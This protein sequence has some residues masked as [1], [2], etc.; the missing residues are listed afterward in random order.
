MMTKVD[1]FSS[2]VPTMEQGLRLLLQNGALSLS[3]DRKRYVAGAVAGEFQGRTLVRLSVCAR[4]CGR[5]LDG[6]ADGRT[7]EMYFENRPEMFRIWA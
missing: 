2:Y 1:I 3:A 6:E 7:F 4:H 5:C